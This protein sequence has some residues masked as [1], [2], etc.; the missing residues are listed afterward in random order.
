MGTPSI[1]RSARSTPRDHRTNLAV[2]AAAPAADDALRRD[3]A[4]DRGPH[5]DKAERSPAFA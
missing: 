2:P 5:C 3:G 4:R 1:G